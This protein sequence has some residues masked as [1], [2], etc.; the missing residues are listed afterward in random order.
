MCNE[1]LNTLL[2]LDFANVNDEGN[3]LHSSVNVLQTIDGQLVIDPD[4]A[5]TGFV[6]QVG[7]LD[8]TNNRIRLKCNL[9]VEKT[10]INGSSEMAVIFQ[11]MTGGNVLYEACADFETISDGINYAYFIDRVFK[12]DNPIN[13]PLSIRILVPD[14]WQH[15]V[16]L[17]DLSIVD[18]N[19]CE[20]NVRTYF[21]IDELLEDS[22]TALSGGLK[23][24]EWKVDG[25]ET[26]T[27]DFFADTNVVGGNPTAQWL[28]AK[29]DIDGSNRES[30]DTTP[31]TFN[32]FKEE[33][34]LDF[35]TVNSFHGG[36]PLATTSGAD[37][38]AGIM[39][40]GL[41]KPA[42]LNG[43][44]NIKKG[45]FFIDIDYSKSLLVKFDVI[46]NQTSQDLFVRPTYIKQYVIE[47]NAQTCEKKFYYT[48]NQIEVD[49]IHNGFLFG[50]TGVEIN[51]EIVGC[52]EAF[53]PTGASGNFTYVLDFGT[54]IGNAGIN[55]NAY[56]VPDRF[57]L[58]WNGQ[59]FDSGF[60][61]S[62]TYDQQLVNAGVN[63]S[64]INTANPSNGSGSLNFVK[65]SANPRTATITVLAPLGGTG[66]QVTGICPDDSQTGVLVEIGEGACGINVSNWLNVYIDESDPSNY[67]PTNGDVIYSD[68]G[69]TT[70]F[71]GGGKTYQMRVSVPPFQ[72]VLD[73]SFEVDA[74][75]V[76]SNVLSCLPPSFAPSGV[77]NN[78]CN[79]SG[80]GQINVFS[81]NVPI[82]N[83]FV[84]NSGTVVSVDAIFT[85]TNTNQVITIPG[86]E[87]RYIPT[88]N[89]TWE[90]PAMDCT[91]GTGFNQIHINQTTF[92]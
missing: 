63:V 89:W 5:T 81:G 35:D 44:L 25:V 72:N 40:I 82:F 56:S 6:R 61:G 70:P 41:E 78:T 10:D 8:V 59:V 54:G 27:P 58:E 57:L 11:L 9:E 3:W 23:M 77:A 2:S 29:A 71:D 62:N 26:L 15:K 20:D 65:T 21:V 28:F 42:I 51:E 19:F 74:N 50:L 68:S 69:L 53:S 55:Y 34:K 7:N 84:I 48:L 73:Y 38:G 33:F 49:E 75:G 47:W 13:T 66:W 85:N 90:I 60:V 46:I 14:G 31:N 43:N 1:N 16:F 52:D 17:S 45:A 88:G 92:P 30:E 4:S 12:Y 22:Q 83:R 76:I 64:D 18:Y 86:G 91:N 39:Q 87:F 67:I 37:Y 32:P 24:N 36:K 79:N 80:N